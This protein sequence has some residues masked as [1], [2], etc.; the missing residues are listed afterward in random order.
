MCRKGS[1]HGAGSPHL[2][3]FLFALHVK[4]KF[5]SWVKWC[6][7][8]GVASWVRY[9]SWALKSLILAVRVLGWSHEWEWY[10]RRSR[11][12]L[13]LGSWRRSVTVLSPLEYV[14]LERA[15]HDR[16]KR[17]YYLRKT[18]CVHQSWNE[19]GVHPVP[20]Q[21]PMLLH[22]ETKAWRTLRP[23]PSVYYPIPQCFDY[24]YMV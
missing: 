9:R 13:L 24:S 14:S 3:L 23:T 4:G 15:R 10:W 17:M 7:I 21:L 2:I 19:Y 12:G 20:I 11:V 6:E 1:T 22:Q 5:L 8:A 18:L 16:D